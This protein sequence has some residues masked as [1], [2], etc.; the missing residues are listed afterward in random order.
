M[1]ARRTTRGVVALLLLAPRAA[2]AHGFG[3]RYD[4]PVPLW[5][6]MS[7]A[8]A[9]VACSFLVIARFASE[10]G[11]ARRPARLNLLRWRIARLVA[12]RRPRT[13]AQILSVALLGLI[14]AA[15]IF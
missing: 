15:G 2:L 12:D 3:Q 10:H 13:V 1:N 4:L 8:A 7:A 11:E 9:A 14:V 5:L 6:W